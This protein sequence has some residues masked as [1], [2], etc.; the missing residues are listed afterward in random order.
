MERLR[1]F[2]EAAR[3]HGFID[4]EET[5]DG[6]VLWLKKATADAE[7]RMCIDS[8]SDSVT[9]F[10]ATIPWKINSRTFRSV[11]T[12]QQ[13]LVATAKRTPPIKTPSNKEAFS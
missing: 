4:A 8:L 9:V 12:L 1:E 11:S 5:K 13:W 7:D 2:Q 3:E 10:W 6:T